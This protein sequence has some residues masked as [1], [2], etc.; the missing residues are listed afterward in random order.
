MQAVDR[1]RVSGFKW[2]LVL[3]GVLHL[4]CFGAGTWVGFWRATATDSIRAEFFRERLRFR[5]DIAYELQDRAQVK[6]ALE[7]YWRHLQ[8]VDDVASVSVRRDRSTCL[9]M[10]ATVSGSPNQ[11]GSYKGLMADAV[12]ECGATNR[13]CDEG[14]LIAYLRNAYP[15]SPWLP[16]SSVTGDSAQPSSTVHLP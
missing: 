2:K 8:L 16:G 13:G 9:A 15:L 12:T 4:V 3:L 6:A 1:T 10:L 7:E 5:A 11:D 14:K